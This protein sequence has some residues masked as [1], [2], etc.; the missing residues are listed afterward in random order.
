MGLDA[1]VML[2][3]FILQRQNLKLRG[4][5]ERDGFKIHLLEKKNVFFSVLCHYDTA[6][7]YLITYSNSNVANFDLSPLPNS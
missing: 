1:L 7:S 4:V 5:S 2:D 3:R 6:I